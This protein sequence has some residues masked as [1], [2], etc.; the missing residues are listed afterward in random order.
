MQQTK[1]F[2]ILDQFLSFY[3]LTTQKIKILGKWKKHMEIL[4]LYTCVP[5]NENYMWCMVPEIWNTTKFFIIMGHFLPFHPTNPKNQNFEKMK[6]TL[7]ILLKN[8]CTK[9]NDHMLYCFWDMADDRCNFYF[10]FWAVCSFIPLE[11]KK[12]RFK[13]KNEKN[14]LFWL[15]YNK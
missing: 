6:K 15:V 4:L 13:K 11:P 7:E 8:H 10:S 14:A 2:V 12:S 3:P 9:N 5:K 1:C